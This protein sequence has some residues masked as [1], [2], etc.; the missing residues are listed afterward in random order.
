MLN[1]LM[2]GN[3]QSEEYLP[4]SLIPII[5]VGASISGAIAVVA[6]AAAA[7]KSSADDAH[8]RIDNLTVNL[9]GDVIGTNN[10]NNQII[11]AFTPNPRFT[12]KGYMKIPVGN[13]AER[14]S[15]PE[16][17]MIRYNLEI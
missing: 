5:P 3:F 7:A 10:I 1:T 6:T 15:V 17:G 8:T 9:I 2:L 16:T 11:T 13:I 14:P 12:G 4:Y